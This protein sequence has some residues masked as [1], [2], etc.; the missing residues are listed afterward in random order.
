MRLLCCKF[1][2]LIRYVDTQVVDLFCCFSFHQGN[3]NK[4][5]FQGSQTLMSIMYRK[6]YSI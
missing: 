3:N 5:L 6:H 4:Q 1:L 2:V